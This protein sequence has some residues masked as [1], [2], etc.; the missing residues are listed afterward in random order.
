MNRF[1]L[2]VITLFLLPFLSFSQGIQMPKE[3]NY[4][5]FSEKPGSIVLNVGNQMFNRMNSVTM[6]IGATVE[7]TVLPNLTAGPMFTYFKF[8]NWQQVQKSVTE[9]ENIDV[10]YNQ[11]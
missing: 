2:I 4:K 1:F 5:I 10:K 6:P 9:Y 11:Y 7:V 8:V 3:K